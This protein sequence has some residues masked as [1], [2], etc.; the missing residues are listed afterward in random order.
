L[1]RSRSPHGNYHQQIF[2]PRIT[3]ETSRMAGFKPIGLNLAFVRSSSSKEG[4][5]VLRIGRY[6][7]YLPAEG[8]FA[9]S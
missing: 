8:R 5:R 6:A 1:R 9:T 3:T 7:L 2:K 4:F